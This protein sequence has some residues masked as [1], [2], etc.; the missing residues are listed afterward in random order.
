VNS[1]DP[2]P[3]PGP[4]STPSS[5]LDGL[6]R[7]GRILDTIPQAVFWKDL[8]CIY[9]GCNA[10]FA[11]LAGLADPAAV[12]G[13]SDSDL[14]WTEDEIA[15][16]RADDREVMTSGR[17]R[18][19]ILEPLRRADGK[20]AWVGTSKM[21]LRDDAGRILGVVGI[22]EDMTE[23][24]RTDERLQET[25][26]TLQTVLDT[27][28]ARVFW[29]DT[30]C[31]YLGCNHR[32]ALDAGLERPEQI[33]GL[34]DDDVPWREQAEAYRA[35]DR[36]VMTTGVPKLGYEEPQTTPTGRTI[37][38]RTSKIPLRDRTGDVI[39]VMGT[40]EDITASKQA[41]Q[42]RLRLET[43]M[44]QAQKLE[45]LGILAGGIAHDFNNLLVAILGHAELALAD[46]AKDA[47]GRRNVAEI[48]IAAH[49]A[50]ELTNQMLAYS[51]KGRFQVRRLRL[52]EVVREMGNLLEAALP[53]KVNLRYAMPPDLPPVEVDVAQIRQVV[54]NLVTNAAEA[55]GDATGTIT[56][57]AGRERVAESLPPPGG[58]GDELPPGDYVF[59]EV[60][61]TGC[62]MDARTRQRIFDPF[63]T[64]KFAGRGLGMAAVLGIVRGHAGTIEIASEPDRGCRIRVLL[65]A[66][67]AGA[68]APAAGPRREATP[69]RGSG[70]VLVVDDE[71]SV[72]GIARQMLERRGFA[73]L[74]AENG[75]AAVE[76][77]RQHRHEV[78]VVLL[79]LTMPRMDGR[80]TLAALRAVD[81]Q[82]RAVLTSGYDEREATAR[83]A[84]LQ[85]AGFLAKPFT[86]TDLLDRLRQA[87]ADSQPSS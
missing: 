39:G 67:P 59:C 29:K 65:P 84:D 78:A 81:P 15:M 33:V 35:D 87:L 12:V 40:Y 79:D 54:M 58:A 83:F 46:M 30:Q 22:I 62:G 75:E 77:F 14:P 5:S 21:P 70:T 48:R 76:V 10:A 44:Q 9:L 55:I 51:G 45:S 34:T 2:T 25:R 11:R 31:V 8:D 13:L 42:E 52:D 64:T 23:H 49:R 85:V 24:R 68:E 6:A 32:F 86:L 26:R 66:A 41:E 36:Q 61:D 18:L 27:I 82:V 63:F 3:P 38:L 1:R 7:M 50:S 43:R 47:A 17:P 72:R 4:A 80:E 37:W 69:W 28:P 53:K 60:A 71:P 56:I 73:V 20:V 19:H 74:C 16:Y 57:T